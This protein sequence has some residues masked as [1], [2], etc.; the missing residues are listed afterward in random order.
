[1]AACDV[2]PAAVALGGLEH[3]GAA[4]GHGQR[5]HGDPAHI[6]G[7]LEAHGLAL[8]EAR[9]PHAH[10]D[11]LASEGVGQA[12]ALH[13]RVIRQHGARHPGIGHPA[14]GLAARVGGVHHLP[15]RLAPREG[16]HEQVDHRVARRRGAHLRGGH[17][18]GMSRTSVHPAPGPG[19]SVAQPSFPRARSIRR[20]PAIQAR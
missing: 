15:R 6:D 9:G 8:A 18:V 11:A 1:M 19:S 3:D 10:V 20:Q 14:G 4:L 7:A 5:R 2:E 13:H 12:D 17:R 16:G